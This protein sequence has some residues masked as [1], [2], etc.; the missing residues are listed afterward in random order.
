MQKIL[1]ILALGISLTISLNGMESQNRNK[2]LSIDLKIKKTLLER[3]IKQSRKK[4][5][6]FNLQV[7]KMSEKQVAKR[8][9]KY[10][11][12]LKELDP[13]KLWHGKIYLVRAQIKTYNYGLFCKEYKI[14]RNG[15]PDTAGRR[16][17][18]LPK[19]Y[20]QAFAWDPRVLA[21]TCNDGSGNTTKAL[22]THLG[23]KSP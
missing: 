16:T 21:L 15:K 4:Y 23:L 8:L 18:E 9:K 11:A 2:F 12:Y 17:L 3:V 19:Q 6:P 5:S 1:R 20:R 22:A 13:T 10:E 14:S 7:R